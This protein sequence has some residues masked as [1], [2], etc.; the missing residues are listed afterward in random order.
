MPARAGK[1]G[2]TVTNKRHALRSAG[3]WVGCVLLCFATALPGAAAAPDAW[4]AALRKPD[5]TPP[6]WVFG[7]VWTL[8]YVLM[9]TAAWRVARQPRP[10]RGRAL[11]AF[12]A[13]LLFNAAW[14]PLFFG[15]HQPAW[16]LADLVAMG[17]TL[18]W[19]GRQFARLDRLAGSLL[20]PYAGWLLFAGALNAAI[21]V[22]NR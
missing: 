16:A 14:S 11:A 6:G 5:W 4:Y 7:P 19:A 18:A 1:G 8:L 3:V 9:G 13:H 20:M 17:V 22:L 21:V 12:G 15:V 2:M 10:G